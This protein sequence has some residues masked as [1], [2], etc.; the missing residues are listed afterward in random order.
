MY[1]GERRSVDAKLES[2]TAGLWIGDTGDSAPT[3]VAGPSVAYYG[4]TWW[5]DSRHLLIGGRGGISWIDAKHP[6]PSRPLIRSSRLQ[7]PWSISP[8]GRV[9]YHELSEST[10]LDLWTV[11]IT[12]TADGLTAGAPEPFRQTSAFEVYPAFS[13]DGR[14]IAYGSNESGSTE[15][16]VRHYPDDGTVVRVS[17][18]GGRIPA[19]SPSGRELLYQTDNNRLMVAA[20]HF[21]QGAFVA[22]PP[23]PWTPQPL[24]EA[25]C[26]NRLAD[27]SCPSAY[28][29]ATG[30]AAFVHSA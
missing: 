27:Y 25:I 21:E 28:N 24:D 23:R 11:P 29:V 3:R 14:W 2:G 12:A 1:D 30:Q 10:G 18:G 19:W 8:S 13:P 16:D 6:A 26:R 20:Y 9:A 7:V 15:V 17:V 5:P 4:L 22:S